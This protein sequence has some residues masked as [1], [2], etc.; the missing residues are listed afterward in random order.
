MAETTALDAGERS[1][2]FRTSAA[3]ARPIQSAS[4]DGGQPSRGPPA[5]RRALPVGDVYAIGYVP[6]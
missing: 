6:S 1:N 2:R 5:Y 3:H 4:L